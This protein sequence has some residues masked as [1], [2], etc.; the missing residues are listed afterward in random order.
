[1]DRHAILGT[2]ATEHIRQRKMLAT[3]ESRI[4]YFAFRSQP[5]LSSVYVDGW[6]CS[7]RERS[8]L[9][10]REIQ[11]LG[12]EVHRFAVLSPFKNPSIVVSENRTLRPMRTGLSL[13]DLTNFQ[14]VVREI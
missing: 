7:K 13:R 11:S 5:S 1:M 9:L 12:G 3:P 10:R 14:S 4:G 2:V 6:L 8:R